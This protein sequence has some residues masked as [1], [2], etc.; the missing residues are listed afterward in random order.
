MDN[1]FTFKTLIIVILLL[2]VLAFILF[3]KRGPAN[4]SPIEGS[5]VEDEY[6][7]VA[8]E[9]QRVL[10]QLREAGS[11]LSKPHAMEFYLHFPTEEAANMVALR[12][13][14]EGFQAEVKEELPGKAWL[15]YVTKQ[16][17][18]DGTR[19]TAIG[20]RFTSLA[21]E[22]QGE[23]TGWETSLEHYN[24]EIRNLENGS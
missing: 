4:P 3:R 22:Y 7:E 9:D 23:Y 5:L 21:N 20:H 2:G 1:Y 15:C 10:D 6:L 24:N 19:I 14:S 16:M 12:V 13:R 17:V 11:D 18:P 8:E